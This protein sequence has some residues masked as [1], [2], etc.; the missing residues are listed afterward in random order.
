M[1]SIFRTHA[2]ILFA[3]ALAAAA[4]AGVYRVTCKGIHKL[5]T[6]AVGDSCAEGALL[7][8]AGHGRL[9]PSLSEAHA[10]LEHGILAAAAGGGAIRG[11][12]YGGRESSS[13]II[14][15]LRLA[16]SWKG[17][18]PVEIIMKLRYRFEGYGESR[19]NASLR[20]STASAMQGDHQASVH[21]RYTGLGG[22]VMI[23]GVTKG[24]FRQP[25]DGIIANRAA[26]ELKVIQWVDAASPEIEV[27]A[28][29]AAYA[30][31]NLGVFEESL[32]S[33]VHANGEIGFAAPCPLR[34]EAPLR[35]SAW[36]AK[37]AH[38]GSRGQGFQC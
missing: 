9:L 38:W 15:R 10:D 25:T 14:E 5:S 35:T 26:I 22:A 13:V 37:T 19:L 21:V 7:D 27:R 20:S 11:V 17:V 6:T 36:S 32:M 34:I 31:P 2:A 4:S 33:L 16:G 8:D 23:A 29:L 12:G 1:P 18:M 28:D 3:A 30:L 24:H